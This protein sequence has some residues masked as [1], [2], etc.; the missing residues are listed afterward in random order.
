MTGLYLYP[1]VSF[2]F[3]PG[4]SA[5]LEQTAR[6]LDHLTAMV[7]N[8]ESRP[9]PACDLGGVQDHLG[10]AVSA[11][12]SQV[13][14]SLIQLEQAADVHRATQSRLLQSLSDDL[15]QTQ[16]NITRLLAGLEFLT[17]SHNLLI[18]RISA[19]PPP[20]CLPCAVFPDSSLGLPDMPEPAGLHGTDN[21]T[22]TDNSTNCVVATLGAGEL[23]VCYDGADLPGSLEQVLLYGQL[24]FLHSNKIFSLLGKIICDE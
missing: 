24:I 19:L 20:Q 4:F 23:R 3:F 17:K 2:Y 1:A 21:D 9:P 10:L 18:Q 15:V 13:I 6:Q 16:H 12:G 22:L 14:N 7:A 8:L 11:Q 5:S